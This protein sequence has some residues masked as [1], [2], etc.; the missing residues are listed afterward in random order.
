MSNDH[1][2]V[3]VSGSLFSRI[4]LNSLEQSSGD[5]SLVSK[6]VELVLNHMKG[7]YKSLCKRRTAHDQTDAVEI[8]SNSDGEATRRAGSS[9]PTS[10]PL[11]P[12]VP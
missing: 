9:P 8:V 4:S 1:P 5:S 10:P 12:L 6:Q 7:S 2:S 3:R 11:R